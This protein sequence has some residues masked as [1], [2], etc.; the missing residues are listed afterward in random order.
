MVRPICCTMTG[1]SPSV[2][3]SSSS[4]RAPVRRMRAIASICCSPPDSRVPGAAARVPSGW[5]TACRWS[6]MSARPAPRPAAASGSRSRSASRRC[7]APPG[8]S[9]MPARAIRFGAQARSSPAPL[10]LMLPL[11]PRHQAHDRLHRRGLAGAVAA[12]QGHHLALAH[13]EVDAVQN[14]ALA[15][16]GVQAADFSRPPQASAVPR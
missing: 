4:I 2:G 9:A 10:K 14:V 15:V 6:A 8:R 3:S 12:E 1:A 5:G 16:P 11:A 13:V 7:R